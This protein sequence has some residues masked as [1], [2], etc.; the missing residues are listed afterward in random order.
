MPF[1]AASLL[2]GGAMVLFAARSMA[3]R[4]GS[5]HALVQVVFVYA[6]L[7]IAWLVVATDVEM[8]LFAFQLKLQVATPGLDAER[9][10][11]FESVQQTVIRAATPLAILMR[12]SVAA[13]IVLA[14]TRP[15][16]RAFFREA[17]QGTLGEG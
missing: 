4:E 12:T 10:R 3:G 17:P 11:A 1:G 16:A 5:R 6:G 9:L 2:L 7:T 14:L 13:L 15:R 8:A